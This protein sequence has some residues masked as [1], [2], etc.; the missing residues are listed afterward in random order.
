MHLQCRVKCFPPPSIV[1]IIGNVRN[2]RI[3]QTTARVSI[4][5][6]YDFI[7]NGEPYSRSD[8]YIN[9][10]TSDNSG[11]YTCLIHAD[12]HAVVQMTVHNVTVSCKAN[13]LYLTFWLFMLTFLLLA[14]NE[15]EQLPL[16]CLNGATCFDYDVGYKCLCARGYAGRNCS[17]SMISRKT[18]VNS[19]FR[20]CIRTVFT[21]FH[22]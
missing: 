9:H 12:S 14:T 5:D 8:L 6:T 10:V 1:W 16:V 3:L 2:S 13:S 7:N 21:M 11:N 4:S 22:M 18:C 19:V 17:Q 15:C 20:S